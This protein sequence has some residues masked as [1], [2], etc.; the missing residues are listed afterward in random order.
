MGRV[1]DEPSLSLERALESLEEGVDDAGQPLELLP[2]HRNPDPL[3]EVRR[4]DGTGQPRDLLD[5]PQ[6]AIEDEREDRGGAK[7]TDD[8]EP[9]KGLVESRKGMKRRLDRPENDERA[10]TAFSPES[11]H[12]ETA[13]S[14]LSAVRFDGGVGIFRF[15]PIGREAERLA[16][17]H[18]IARDGEHAVSDEEDR[19][20]VLKA[21]L[22]D[23]RL[24][25][26]AE[27]F[28][29]AETFHLEIGADRDRESPQL[30]V[31]VVESP[32]PHHCACPRPEQQEQHP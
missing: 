20:V 3:R 27:G 8:D 13:H 12:E 19:R 4:L 6:R 23:V 2:T 22:E 11:Q 17:L 29:V 1:G 15:P 10:S 31:D 16:R 24:E 30:L 28:L 18:E 26:L 5:R 9:G 32:L 14:P 7:E 25:A 21:E